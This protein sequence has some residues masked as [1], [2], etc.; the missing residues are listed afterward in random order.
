MGTIKNNSGFKHPIISL[1]F[2][3]VWLL[4]RNLIRFYEEL[5]K[6]KQIKKELSRLTYKVID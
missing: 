5:A 3:L 6:I 2:S 1:L 4:Q